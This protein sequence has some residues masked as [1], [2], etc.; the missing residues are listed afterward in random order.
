MHNNANDIII[1]IIIIIVSIITKR[2]N[3][4]A[5]LESYSAQKG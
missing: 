4:G 5:Q 3:C 2:M 1:T